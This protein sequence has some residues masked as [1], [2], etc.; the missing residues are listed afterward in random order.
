M[1]YAGLPRVR[2]LFP[3]SLSFFISFIL[4]WITLTLCGPACSDK[5]SC[6]CSIMAPPPP[7]VVS[8]LFASLP[9][10]CVPPPIPSHRQL[11][12]DAAVRGTDPLKNR[13]APQRRGNDVIA[14]SVPMM[15]SKQRGTTRLVYRQTKRLLSSRNV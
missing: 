4:S 12:L 11:A 3:L 9:D 2:E 1:H 5:V 15:T 7:N 10:Q 14:G 8:R 13:G 6:C